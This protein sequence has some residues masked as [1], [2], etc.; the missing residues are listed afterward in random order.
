MKQ[1]SDEIGTIYTDVQAIVDWNIK[2]NIWISVFFIIS[3]YECPFTFV[4]NKKKT[5]LERKYVFNEFM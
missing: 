5:Q 3:I 1:W 4:Q 2:Q